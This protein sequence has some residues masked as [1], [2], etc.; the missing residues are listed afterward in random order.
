[1]TLDGWLAFVTGNCRRIGRTAAVALGLFVLPLACSTQSPTILPRSP[2]LALPP[3][4]MRMA[5]SLRRSRTGRNGTAHG[6][7]TS[8]AKRAC[9][10]HGPKADQSWFG[11]SA[12]WAAAGPRQSLSAT[13]STLPA[14]WATTWSSSPSTSTASRGGRPTTA[15]RGQGSYPGRQGVLRL[16]RRQALPHERPR[17]RGLPGGRRRARNYGRSTCWSGSRQQNITWAMSECLL[18]DGPRL[19]V[20]PGGEKAL[21]AAPRQTQRPDDLDH[22]A[23]GRRPGLA[24]L[25]DLFRHAGR[26]ILANCSSAHGFAVDADTG[27]LLWTVPLQSPYGVNI[28]TPVYGAEPDLLRDPLRLRDLLPVAAGR[29]EAAAG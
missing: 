1:M 4:T 21:M 29:R 10:P 20:T 18:V 11:K 25:A 28:T 17:P 2:T 3:S 7:T 12:T 15:D 22:R 13:A 16:L 27:K 19:I 23:A 6:G 26:R 8:P 24:L 14:T 5:R 9:C